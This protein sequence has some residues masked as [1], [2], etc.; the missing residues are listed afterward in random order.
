MSPIIVSESFM[1][2]GLLAEA[3]RM[4]R[5]VALLALRNGRSKQWVLFNFQFISAIKSALPRVEGCAMVRQASGGEVLERAKRLVVEARTVDELRQGQVAL[6]PLEFGL[7]LAQTAQAN[8]CAL[9]Y[10]L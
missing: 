1:S 10:P 6:L 5:Q 2:V 9:K 8:G 3:A 4:S 7:T